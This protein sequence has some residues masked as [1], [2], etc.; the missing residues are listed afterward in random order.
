[1]TRSAS[2]GETSRDT[3]TRNRVELTSIVEG[4]CEG[5]DNTRHYPLNVSLL[6]ENDLFGRVGTNLVAVGMVPKRNQIRCYGASMGFPGILS[7]WGC[8]TG[9]IDAPLPCICLRLGTPSANARCWKVTW[10]VKRVTFQGKCLKRES[11]EWERENR[12][13]QKSRFELTVY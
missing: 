1:M 11:A 4:I 2:T 13:F 6:M 12:L 8:R 10:S 9:F 3:A 5:N 7:F